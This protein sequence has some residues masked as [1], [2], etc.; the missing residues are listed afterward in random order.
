ML[1]PAE[2]AD[3][4]VIARIQVAAWRAT[5]GHLN[6]AMV[7]GLDLTRTTDNWAQ[8]A[9]D[10]A[11]RLRLTECDGTTVGYAFSGPG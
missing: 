3:G 8:A 7:D 2:A 5:Y 9:A 6:P 4:G 1:R 11:H 10:P